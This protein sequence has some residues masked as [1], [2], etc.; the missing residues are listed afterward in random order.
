[1]NWALLGC[2]LLLFLTGVGNLYSASGMRLEDGIT[3]SSFY[4]RQ[5]IWGLIG[6]AVM[7]LAITFD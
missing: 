3:V 4:Q 7:L 5:M 2:A 6:F 1:M